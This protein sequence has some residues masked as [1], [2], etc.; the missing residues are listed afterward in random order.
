[1]IKSTFINKNV[2][3]GADNV[4]VPPF[5]IEMSDSVF[6]FSHSSISNE[7]SRKRHIDEIDELYQEQV[8]KNIKEF[9]FVFRKV[10]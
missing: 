3:I 5:A 1:M 7:C 2:Y 9:T 8:R 6:T 4:F 10:D